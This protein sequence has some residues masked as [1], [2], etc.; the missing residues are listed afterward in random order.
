MIDIDNEV[1]GDIIPSLQE[2]IGQIEGI[3]TVRV[4]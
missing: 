1:N 3:V 4:I 2:K